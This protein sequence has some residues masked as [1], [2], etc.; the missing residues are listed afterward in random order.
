MG[1]ALTDARKAFWRD[2]PTLITGATGLLGSWLTKTLVNAG[3]QVVILVRDWVPNSELVRSTTL[4]RVSVVRGDI[5]DATTMQRT[6]SEYEVDTCFH[7][8]AQTTVGI[9]NRMPT[10]TFETNIKGTWTL[11]EAARQWPEIKRVIVASSDKAY[12]DQDILPYDENTPLQGLHPYDVSKSC[13]DLITLTYA[14][15]YK[16]PVAITRC[17]NMYGGGDLNWNRIVPGTIRWALRGEQPLVRSDG[18]LKRDYV[19]VL[20]IVDA[21]LTLAEHMIDGALT[22]E[23]FNFGLN[24]PLSV[25]EMVHL[26]ID[27]SPYPDLLPIV[28]NEARNEIKDQY[29]DS[30]KAMSTLGWK[31]LY[32]LED[33]L[34]LTM[35]WYE[36]YLEHFEVEQS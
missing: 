36:D 16:L 30:H 5:A 26:I 32:T 21:Y 13:A 10:P 33:G 3:A 17:G 23:A 29:L 34:R 20:D 35:A 27:I 19:F 9:A 22:G 18:T 4:E 14:H 2:R 28:L 8:A 31:P 11:L 12:G 7:L 6:F 25:L 24:Q 15:T 1:L